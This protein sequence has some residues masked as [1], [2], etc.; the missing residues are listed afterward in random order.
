MEDV[1]HEPVIVK[2]PEQAGEHALV[3]L[4]RRPLRLA[5]HMGYDLAGHLV[6]ET[7]V[8]GLRESFR[9]IGKRRVFS[10]LSDGDGLCNI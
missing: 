2:G 3:H 7:E 10:V 5:K 6:S 4:L 8:E 1:L 9:K